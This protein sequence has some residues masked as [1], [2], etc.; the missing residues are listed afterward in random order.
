MG[1]TITLKSLISSIFK[2]SF[3]VMGIWP[4]NDQKMEGRMDPSEAFVQP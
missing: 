1:I 4:F 2:K 3:A